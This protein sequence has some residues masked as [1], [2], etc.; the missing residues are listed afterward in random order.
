M[1]TLDELLAAQADQ[2]NATADSSLS[3]LI[4]AKPAPAGPATSLP[5]LNMILQGSERNRTQDYN[6]AQAKL[7][8]AQAKQ[9]ETLVRQM[10]DQV[11]NKDYAG[12]ASTLTKLDPEGAKVIIPKLMD[13]DPTIREA[14]SKADEGGKLGAQ[15][16]SRS[17]PR[18]LLDAQLAADKEQKLFESNARKDEAA[19]KP[20]AFT[21]TVDKKFAE[22]FLEWEKTG[23]SGVKSNLKQLDKAKELLKSGTNSTG[24]LVGLLPKAARDVVA[25]DSGKIQ[26]IVQ[27]VVMP[28]LRPILGAAFTA[29]EGKRVV[30]NTFNPRLSREENQ[31]RLGILEDTVTE[32]A[33]AKQAMADWVKEKK[34]LDGYIGPRVI[35]GTANDVLSHIA[36]KAGIETKQVEGKTYQKVDGGWSLVK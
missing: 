19:A 16:A 32:Q 31:R 10:G 26:D 7:Q 17:N 14:L 3:E 21:E 13:A 30:E 25:P 24:P 6:N 9:K 12:A 34:T 35:G 15:T 1:P 8:Q 28:T 20:S 36:K 27:A 11:K 2:I 22:D 33:L 23:L 29:E 5:G 18:Q 4:T